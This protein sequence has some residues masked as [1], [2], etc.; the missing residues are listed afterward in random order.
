MFLTQKDIAAHPRL[1]GHYQELVANREIHRIGTESMLATYQSA[2]KQSPQ[3]LAFNALAGISQQYWAEIDRQIVQYRDQE[4]GMEILNDLLRVQ[5]VLPIGKTAKMYNIVGDI[6]ED[7]AVSIDGQA[8]YSFDHTE[9]SNDGDP[10]PVFTAGFGVNWRHNAGLQ[11]VGID[12][13]LD[14]QSAKNRKF[15]KALV[16][17]TLDGSTRISVDGMKGEGLRN[18]R[19]TVKVN[20]GAGAGGANIDLTTAT[21]EQL[22]AFF[23]SGAFGQTARDNKVEA[24]DVLWVSP[25]IWANLSRP[26]LIQLGS[27]GGTVAGSVLQAVSSFIPAREIRQT[28][29]FTGNEYLAYVR[30]QDVVSPL[31]GMATGVVP[32]PRLMPQANH[33]FQIMAAMG[34]QV[35]RDGEAKS[36]VQYGAVL[37]P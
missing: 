2:I 37:V 17:Y 35:K 26:Y 15:Q 36:G 4:T 3:M 24:Y 1:L 28:F 27:S 7:V 22:I 5:T 21:P 25:Q 19:N 16:A 6:A 31:V 20:L 29:A 23:S 11:T 33:N 10:I 13:I 9:Y 18:H 8:P 32:L 30:R 34:I 14:S 12:L